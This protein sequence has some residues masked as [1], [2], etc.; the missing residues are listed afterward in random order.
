MR[1]LNPRDL[2]KRIDNLEKNGGG[3]G[4]STAWSDVTGK[5]FKTLSSDDFKVV[6][7]Q[8]Q[9]KERGST[10]STPILSI[11]NTTE[12]YSHTNNKNE[13]DVLNI[14]DT[15][16]DIK[17][18]GAWHIVM[19]TTDISDS[20]ITELSTTEITAIIDSIPSITDAIISDATHT[21]IWDDES[22]RFDCKWEDS[23]GYGNS[24]IYPS[25]FISD[26]YNNSIKI[27]SNYD[28]IF[29]LV[30]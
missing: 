24:Y 9:L 11:A 17:I 29:N 16:T 1:N 21:A 5:P 3:G 27:A 7:S 26:V 23:T 10:G 13:I 19:D 2:E 25:R 8:L 14:Y 28:T 30:I 15:G 6:G 18:M 4:G 12:V 22:K 20:V